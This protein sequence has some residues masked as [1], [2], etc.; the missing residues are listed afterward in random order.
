MPIPPKP[1][2]VQIFET[3]PPANADTFSKALP[4]AATADH[5]QAIVLYAPDLQAIGSIDNTTSEAT[6]T[7]SRSV[8]SGFTFSTTQT[9]SVQASAEVT[10]EVVKASLTVGF[11]ISFTEQWST[12]K[13]TTIGFSVPPG[14]KA[15]TY[16]GYLLS[17]IINFDASSGTYSYGSTARFV[18]DILATSNVPLTGAP[19]FAQLNA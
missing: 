19:S 15:F 11:S 18:T 5:L 6:T 16:Q 13:T 7:Y 14:Q 3:L 9:L 1:V 4:T 2:H 8:T 10:I 17:A 12:S